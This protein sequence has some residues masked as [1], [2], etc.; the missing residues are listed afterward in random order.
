MCLKILTSHHVNNKWVPKVAEE[1]ILVY[2]VIFSY[3]RSFFECFQ[4]EPNTQFD[5]NEPLRVTGPFATEA[6]NNLVHQGF[7]A[8][9]GKASAK[10]N[11]QKWLDADVVEEGL[12]KV[13]EFTIPKG[14]S[15][16]LGENDDIVS[17]SIR[18]GNLEP[19]D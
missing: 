7:H 16:F 5:I 17:T 8:Y 2:K 18:A 14:A 11:L 12:A 10:K 3:N 9:M 4:Y 15:Y 13:V 1:D 6:F 19:L